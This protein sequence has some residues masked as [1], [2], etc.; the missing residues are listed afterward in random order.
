[1]LD[2][3]KDFAK[4]HRLI[5]FILILII[6]FLIYVYFTKDEGKTVWEAVWEYTPWGWQKNYYEVQGFRF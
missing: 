5:T 6:I 2:G 4:E 3:I 1:M